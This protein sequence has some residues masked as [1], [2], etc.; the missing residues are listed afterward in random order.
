VKKKNKTKQNKTKQ[1]SLIFMGTANYLP[2]SHEP[3]SNS[4]C[5]AYLPLRDKKHSH[6]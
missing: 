6:T 5:N 3:H 1:K 2:F 4:S